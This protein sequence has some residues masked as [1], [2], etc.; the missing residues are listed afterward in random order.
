MLKK[1]YC[2]KRLEIL[3]NI[4]KAKSQ[5]LNKF[6]QKTFF[7]LIYT[8]FFKNPTTTKTTTTTTTTTTTII[9]D[10]ISAIISDIMS[11]NAV[12]DED[13]RHI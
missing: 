3:I 11:Q 5:N 2:P 13:L 4:E 1:D 10:I 9:S 7:C 12:E 8:K 6:I